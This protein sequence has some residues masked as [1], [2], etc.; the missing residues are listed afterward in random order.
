MILWL[1]LFAVRAFSQDSIPVRILPETDTLIRLPAIQ[2]PAQLKDSNTYIEFF[3]EAILDSLKRTHS[4]R[5]SAFYSA[6]L[7]GLGQ[8]YNKQSWKMPFV[9]AA[10]GV[11]TGFFIWN[12]DQYTTFR[13][14]YR[15]RMSNQNNPNYTDD[16]G[17][18]RDA[19]VKLLRDTYR[20]YVDYSVLVFVAAY[21]LNIIDATVFGHLRKFDVSEDLSLR[22]APTMM[23]YRTPGIKLSLSLDGSKPAYR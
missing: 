11:S 5:R 15:A 1:C 23:D 19:N 18:L 8:A 20:Q 3:S 16:F 12:M 2:T 14:L 17:H 22:L 10:I 13:N 7:P 21:A 6:V 4:P 9:Y